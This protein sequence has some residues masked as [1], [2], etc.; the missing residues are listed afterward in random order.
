MHEVFFGYNTVACAVP[1][2][3]ELSKSRVT[4][5]KVSKNSGKNKLLVPSQ[6]FSHLCSLAPLSLFTQTRS[7]RCVSLTDSLW[8]AVM[9]RLESEGDA[10]HDNHIQ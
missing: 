2:A 10:S 3:W 9:L 1:V 8:H 5:V 6:H 7:E 4:D